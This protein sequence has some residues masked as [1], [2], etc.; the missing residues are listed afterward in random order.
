M[1][2]PTCSDSSTAI[3]CASRANTACASIAERKYFPSS[4]S[5][6]SSTWRRSASPTSTCLPVTVSCM[7][8]H[9]P[10]LRGAALAMFPANDGYDPER[11]QAANPELQGHLLVAATLHRGRDA[12]R[13]PV[14]RDGAARN[15]DAVPLQQLDDLLVRQR[16]VGRLAV[17]QAANAE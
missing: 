4:D 1:P 11:D 16:I 7:A 10:S 17:D 2:R 8:V 14:F 15:F 5:S 6:A 12:H 9:H 3:R 13:L